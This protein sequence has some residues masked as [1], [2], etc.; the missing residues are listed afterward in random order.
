MKSRLLL[1][2]AIVAA[3][4]AFAF[5]GNA[6]SEPR[7]AQA[8]AAALLSR[9][10][11]PETFQSHEL[12]YTQSSAAADG[13]ARAAALLSGRVVAGESSTSVS[14]TTLTVAQEPTDA[15]ARAAALLSGSRSAVDKSSRKTASGNSPGEHPAVLVAR[16]WATRGIDANE[17]IVAHPARL[18][19]IGASPSQ[20]QSI[21][22]GNIRS[23]VA[24]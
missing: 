21:G 13:H 24:R 6:F 2:P 12:R 19:L 9:P 20:E 10:H 18:Q 3:T 7:D 22:S 11:T 8:Q 23:A 16:H 15:H 1:T 5:S 17:F 4:A 14:V